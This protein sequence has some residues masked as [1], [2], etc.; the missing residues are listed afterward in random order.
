MDNRE[1]IAEL[2]GKARQGNQDAFNELYRLT[3]DRAYFVALTITRNEQDALDIVQDS[4]LKAWQ[5][6]DNLQKPEQF[7]AWLNQITGNTAKNYIK[8]HSPLLFLGSD[9]DTDGFFDLQEERDGDYIPDA[10]M[11]T[12][13]TR[14]LIMDIVDALP[15]DQRLCVLMYYYEDMGLPEI[16]TALDIPQSTVTSR[17][18]RARR[19]ISDGVEA[20]AKK[21]TML[22]GGAP[23]SLFVWLLKHLAFESGKNL[24]PVILGAATAGGAAAT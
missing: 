5:S 8:H 6:L 14:R 9:D 12:A 2:A 1:R 13:E 10:A 19:K 18:H 3:R 21:G 16:A 23:M 17:L 11:D 24:P 20:L 4:Y 22:Y 15:E 7:Q